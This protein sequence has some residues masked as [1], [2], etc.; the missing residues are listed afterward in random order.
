MIRTFL[1]P[2]AL[3]VACS[4][5]ADHKPVATTGSAAGSGAAAL[6][7]AELVNFCVRSYGQ[8][9]ECFKDDEFWQVFSTMYFANTNLTSDETERT[10]WIGI[11]KE[12]LLK[13]YNEKGFE[14]NCKTTVQQNKLPSAKSV[15]NV[16][17]AATKS[18]S[19][20]GSAFGYM[21]FNEGAF[22]NPK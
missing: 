19:A 13:L 10:H 15:E 12:D 4:K 17:A 6:S 5:S 20:F 21:V 3:V 7:E 14:E 11:M 8:M 1:I 22:H 18:C 16:R 9:M 2:L